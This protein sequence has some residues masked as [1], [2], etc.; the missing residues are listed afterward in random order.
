MP[1]RMDLDLYNV[2]LGF[3]WVRERVE[4]VRAT[5]DPGFLM[6]ARRALMPIPGLDRPPPPPD[7]VLPQLRRRPIRSL[8]G[9][10]IAVIAGGG[11]GACVSLIGVR[12]AFEE[13]GIEPE[14]ISACS[15]GAIWGSMWAAGLSAEEMVDFS[16]SWHLED[17]LD[18]QW[19][20]LPRY[21]LAMLR[22]FTGMAKGEAIERTF[23]ERF[24][25]LT[26]G[27][28]PIDFASI[29]Y[30]LDRGHVDYFGSLRTPD[31]P[32]ARLVR[33]AIALPVFIESVEVEGHLYVD[34]GIIDL[35]PAAPIIRDGAFDRVFALNFMLPP[36]LE[37]ED[38]TGWEHHRM[39]I[40]QASR[41]AEQGFQLELARRMRDRL[42]D[43]LTVI[44]AA[45]HR[46]LRG[47]SFY[48]LFIDRSRWP[49]LIREGYQRASA[50]LDAFRTRRAVRA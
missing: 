48:D 15:G 38:I 25:D 37:S 3:G 31:L 34:G 4:L 49:E 33:I 46:L 40:L 35:L 6:R 39:G 17:Y 24:G 44:D 50:A 29:V 7:H 22:N 1:G 27:E 2:L 23:A 32:L 28:L 19:A 12:R 42:G 9:E 11:A 26:A 43:T 30:D 8:A 21:A 20:K 13:A 45:D 47:P 16:L 14:L 5:A 10:R 18:I 36:Q 41:Q